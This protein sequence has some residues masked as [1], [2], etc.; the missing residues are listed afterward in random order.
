MNKKDA[1]RAHFLAMSTSQVRNLQTSEDRKHYAKN[2]NS[3]FNFS[4]AEDFARVSKNEVML[5]VSRAA[6]ND[7]LENGAEKDFIYGQDLID[8]GTKPGPSM[9][10]ILD[11]F[12][13][14]QYKGLYKDRDAALAELHRRSNR[15]NS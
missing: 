11:S 8:L 6:I 5:E 3:I 12:R 1:S 9:K 14:E 7:G 13:A 10:N 4:D 2:N 15:R